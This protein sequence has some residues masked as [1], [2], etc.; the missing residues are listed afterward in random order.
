[1]SDL[2]K[3][4]N[5]HTSSKRVAG[6]IGL[7]VFAAISIF[8]VVNDPTLIGVIIWPWAIVTGGLF[9]VSVLEKKL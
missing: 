9:G 8:A 1:M 2:L 7:L 5:G 4:A 3:D 6:F